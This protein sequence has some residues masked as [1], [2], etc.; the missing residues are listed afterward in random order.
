MITASFLFART[1]GVLQYL[2]MDME[3]IIMFLLEACSANVRW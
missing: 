2:Y 1:S 3:E